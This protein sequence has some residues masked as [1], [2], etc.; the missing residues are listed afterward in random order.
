MRV[1]SA[2]DAVLFIAAVM[3]IG[4]GVAGVVMLARRAGRFGRWVTSAW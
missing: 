1:G 3:L 2:L 4:L